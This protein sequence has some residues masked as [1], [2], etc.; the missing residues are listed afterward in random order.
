MRVLLTGGSGYLGRAIVGALARAG[1][2]PIV[3]SRPARAS[4]LPGDVIDGDVRRPD[5]VMGAARG[6]DAIC[7]SAALV[8]VWRARRDDFDETNVA[9]LRNVIDACRA[10]G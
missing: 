2:T 8:S 6:V 7:H 10:C 4:G 5:D 3:F 9:A 1:P